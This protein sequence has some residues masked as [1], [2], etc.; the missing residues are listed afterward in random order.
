MRSFFTLFIASSL[1]ILLASAA[2]TQP[3]LEDN[4]PIDVDDD[5]KAEQE[6]GLATLKPIED[7]KPEEESA[8]TTP[9]SIGDNVFTDIAE[10]TYLPA[11][12]TNAPGK[13]TTRPKKP[14]KGKKKVG[15]SIHQYYMDLSF[16]GKEER[17]A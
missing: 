10:T 6:N 12:S 7:K 3:V 15:Y 14:K 13:V 16:L 1:L 5:K 8:L 9:S 4:K 11:A 2:P 17:K